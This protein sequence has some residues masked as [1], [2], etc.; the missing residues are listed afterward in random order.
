MPVAAKAIFLLGPGGKDEVTRDIDV[1]RHMATN[2]P[3]MARKIMNWSPV[4]ASPHARIKGHDALLPT[5]HIFLE[6][7]TSATEPNANK[8]D[9]AD[10]AYTEAG[11]KIKSRSRLISVEIRGSEVV[12]IPVPETL[13]N[14]TPVRMV[15]IQ[16]ASH[17]VFPSFRSAKLHSDRTPS[18][19]SGCSAT[20]WG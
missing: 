18:L 5:S 12:R 16:K 11:Q 8:V 15:M 6:P 14:V 9:P 2:S 19:L 7:T 13:M 17:F 10:R 1:G 4:R 20:G 3:R